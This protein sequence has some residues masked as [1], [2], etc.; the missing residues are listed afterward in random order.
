MFAT[1]IENSYPTIHDG[2]TRVDQMEKCRH[3]EL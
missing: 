3:Y 1:S 2:R